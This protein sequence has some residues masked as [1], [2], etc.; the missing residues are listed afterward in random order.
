MVETVEMKNEDQV[1]WLLKVIWANE[2][3]T[4]YFL[5]N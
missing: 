4:S 5:D 2:E 1:K 3:T